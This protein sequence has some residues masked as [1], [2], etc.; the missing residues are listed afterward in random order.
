M[1]MLLTHKK[2]PVSFESLRTVEG[3]IYDS[4]R[5]AV[6]ALGLLNDEETWLKTIMEIISYTNDRDQLRSTYASVLVFSDLEDQRGIWE[7]TKDLF[8]SDFLYARGLT[9]YNEEIYRDALDDIQEKVYNNGGA[10]IEE[11][12]LP[13]SRDGKKSSNIIRREKSYNKTRLAE[14]VKEK[15]TTMNTDQ[16]HCY[17]TIMERVKNSKNYSNNGFFINAPGG[18]GKSFLLNALLDTLRS[19]EK[20]ELAIASSGI[21]ATVLHGGRTAHNMFKIPIMDHKDVRACSVK[22]NSEHA[23]LLEMTSLIVWDEAVMANK[24]AITALDITMRDVL[25]ND[26]FIGGVV[27]VCAGDFRQILPVVRE[28]GRGDEIDSCIRSS[29]FWSSLTHLELT[30]NVRLKNNDVLNRGFAEDLL[31]LGVTPSDEYEFPLNFGVL[32]D[33]RE[34]LVNTVYSNLE[35]NFLNVSYFE[36]RVIITPN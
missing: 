16:R 35:D 21:A 13:P 9:E 36:K 30:K 2:G 6:K 7:E 31:K 11:Y 25:G 34:E 18:T 5:E 24:N 8:A 19:T 32:V 26:L 12:G 23:R 22:R 28:G 27:F 1:R 4:Y 14:E 20:I 15:L 10:K 3:V 17:D 33:S 29:Y